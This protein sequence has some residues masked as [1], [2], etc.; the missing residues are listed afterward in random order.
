MNSLYKHTRDETRYFFKLDRQLILFVARMN[1]LNVDESSRSR[2][3][4]SRKGE[5]G[6]RDKYIQ[7]DTCPGNLSRCFETENFL[8]TRNLSLYFLRGFYNSGSRTPIFRQLVFLNSEAQKQKM[9]FQDDAGGAYL[10]LCLGNVSSLFIYRYNE[11]ITFLVLH[12]PLVLINIILRSWI[13]S[14]IKTRL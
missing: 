4:L 6:R 10:E 13:I 7:L 1:P 8:P 5:S 2:V 14:I 12:L 3:M 9:F 11:S